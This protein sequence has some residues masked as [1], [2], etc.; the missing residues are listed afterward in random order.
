MSF[1]ALGAQ[2]RQDL[3]YRTPN[4]SKTRLTRRANSPPT[5]NHN[6]TRQAATATTS[7]TM[8]A[9]STG[10]GSGSVLERFWRLI[11][12][13]SVLVARRPGELDNS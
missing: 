13:D 11:W 4:P 12:M 2:R 9:I 10:L 1:P 7:A 5:L 3:I 6:A 8:N